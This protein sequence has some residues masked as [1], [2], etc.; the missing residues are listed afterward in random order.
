MAARV[1]PDAT[2]PTPISTTIRGP[3]RSISRPRKEL[4]TAVTRK[5]NENAPAVTPCAQPN[6]S[7][8][9][10]RSNEKA[11]RALTPTAMVTKATATI[12]QP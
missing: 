6:S 1:K 12:T 9:G 8:I 7:R 3:L 11:V 5:P 10:G 2:R 4:A